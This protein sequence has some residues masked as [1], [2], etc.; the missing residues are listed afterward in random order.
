MFDDKDQVED[1]ALQE[2]DLE[3][4]VQEGGDDLEATELDDEQGE[5]EGTATEEDKA[6]PALVVSFGDDEEDEAEATPVIRSMRQ[7]LKDQKARIKELEQATVENKAV[8][9]V[10]LGEKPTLESVDYDSDKFET[11]LLEWNATKRD[12]DAEKTAKAE[13]EEAAQSRYMDRLDTYQKAKV[14]LGAKD[15]DDAEEVV[16]ESLNTAQQSIIVANAKRPEILIYA[17][18]KNPDMLKGLAAEQDLA[19]F[20]FR[21]GQMESGMKVT[22]MSTKPTPEKRLKG[23]GTPPM[24]SGSKK[25][26]QLRTEAEKTGDYSKVTAYKKQMRSQ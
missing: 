5:D 17:L 25:L 21:L 14:S 26:E 7:K 13:R 20:A 24:G 22:G 2:D 19:S 15:F 12:M 4:D 9:A 16:R 8:E 3:A 10:Q 23:G 1:V 6:E 11:A 18:G